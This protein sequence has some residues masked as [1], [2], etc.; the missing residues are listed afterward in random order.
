VCPPSTSTDLGQ[1]AIDLAASAGLHLDEWQ[2]TALRIGLAEDGDRWS[3]FEVCVIVARQ[4][5]KDSIFEALQLAKLFLCGDELV[6]HSA[7]EFKTAKEAFRRVWSLIDGDPELRA[8]TLRRVLNPSEQGIDLKSGQRLRFFARTSGSGRGWTADTLI[9]NESFR[10]GGEQM[11]ALL[12]TLSSRPNPQVWYGSSAALAD[13]EQLHAVRKR[14]LTGDAERLA[15]LEWS[16][17][18]DC[19]PADP[20]AWAQANPS[21][22][23][24]HEFIAAEFNAMPLPQ[25]KRERLSIPDVPLDSSHPYPIDAWDVAADPD[26]SALHLSGLVLSVDVPPD[27]GAASVTG[28]GLRPDGI[29]QIEVVDN[30]AGTDWVVPRLV[31]IATRRQFTVVVDGASGAASMIPALEAAGLVVRKTTEREMAAACGEL[32]DALTADPPRVRQVPH[33]ALAMALTGARKR[34]LGDA[35]ALSRRNAS[36]DI[37]PLVAGAL[38]HWLASQGEADVSQSVW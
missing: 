15:Y 23:V 10:L 13:S 21:P 33:P 17:P 7:H 12:P 19:D 14:A 36:A 32:Y 20:K 38:A 11:A 35:W 28:C 22:R 5:G 18:E 26:G 4:N 2:Q 6:I 25:F 24:P 37:S 9:L 1:D 8:R 31:D 27:R 34:P 16:A 29:P 30:A 3:A